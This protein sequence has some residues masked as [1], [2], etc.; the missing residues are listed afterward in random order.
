MYHSVFNTAYV[1]LCCWSR[2][3][4]GLIR[5]L[6]ALSATFD[7]QTAALVL[8]VGYWSTRG[9]EA[10]AALSSIM[11]LEGAMEA[12]ERVFFG[13]GRARCVSAPRLGDTPF[14]YRLIVT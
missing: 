12:S 6:T 10:Q 4:L 3:S 5:W 1:S 14:V 2:A 8:L 13:I 7:P 11:K 9:N